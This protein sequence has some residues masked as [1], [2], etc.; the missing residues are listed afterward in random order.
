M[1]IKCHTYLEGL[2]SVGPVEHTGL[3]GK[4]LES[5]LLLTL[6]LNDVEGVE[7]SVDHQI[8]RLETNQF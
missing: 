6:C 4:D 3:L 5:S 7:S 1:I 2:V 8:A